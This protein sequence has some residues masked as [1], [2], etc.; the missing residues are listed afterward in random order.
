MASR[1]DTPTTWL[2]VEDVCNELGIARST[3]DKWRAKG[4]GPVARKLPNGSL[5]IA[6]QEFDAWLDQL[7]EVA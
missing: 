3:F 1:S 6:R 7:P 5:R 4:V 2:T